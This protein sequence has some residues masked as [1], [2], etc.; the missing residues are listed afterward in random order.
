MKFNQIVKFQV[1]VENCM[2]VFNANNAKDLRKVRKAFIQHIK[3][4][5][6]MFLNNP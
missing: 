1:F 3:L 6:L 4:C 5:E 2:V